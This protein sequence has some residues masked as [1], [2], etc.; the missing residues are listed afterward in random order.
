MKKR[1]K[2]AELALV[3]VPKEAQEQAKEKVQEKPVSDGLSKLTIYEYEQR[4]TKRQNV[5]GAKFFLRFLAATVGVLIFGVLLLV[6]LKVYELNKYAGYVAGVVSLMLY[7]AFF[8]VPTVK[9]MRADYFETNV[10]AY[11]AKKA[12]RHNRRLRHEIADKVIDLTS[13]V[14]GVGWYDS[15][16]VGRL[17]I[18]MRAGDEDGI[19]ICLTQ[20]YRGSVKKS[21]RDLI[22]RSAMR[23]A[24]FSAS[25]QSAKVDAL[26]VVFVNLQLVK[27]LVFLYGFRPSDARLARIF[28]R[29]IQN[30]LVAYGVGTANIGST[31]AKAMSGALK[32]IPLLGTAIAALVDSSV[33]GLVNGT[34][35]TVIGYQTIKFLN[36]EYKLQDILDGV[37]VEDTE[38]EIEETREELEK[39]LKKEKKPATA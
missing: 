27:D 39:Q 21:A 23:S 11:T 18:A 2:S 12:Q 34:L 35:T 24:M 10:N 3:E 19:K 38:A 6:S 13:R 25:S 32:G 20:L 26:L 1:G 5:R 8:I 36:E 16:V 15:E 22:F 37:E 7:I 31:V 9:I 17:A 4:Y 29:V 33:Q 14:E 30:S 28:G